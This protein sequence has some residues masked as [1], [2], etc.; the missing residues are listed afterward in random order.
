MG[1][2]IAPRI[3]AAGRLDTPEHAFELL[4]GNLEKA[5]TLNQL[6]EKRRAI[7]KQY[8]NEAVRQL[9]EQKSIPN[10]I[11]LKNKKWLMISTK[12]HSS[13]W[14]DSVHFSAGRSD[15]RVCKR[16]GIAFAVATIAV[17]A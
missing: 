4:I 17:L 5:V 13:G 1:F 8:V 16:A 6:N 11:V 15:K 7:A 12:D 10:I 9:K 2:Q 3:N 14:D